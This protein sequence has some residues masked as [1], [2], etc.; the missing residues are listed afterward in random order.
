MIPGKL[1]IFSILVALSA[2]NAY[3]ADIPASVVNECTTNEKIYF[4]TKIRVNAD[5]TLEQKTGAV[6]DALTGLWIYENETEDAIYAGYH[7]RKHYL[8][9]AIVFTDDGLTTI[10]CDS[11]NM[12]QREGSIHRKAPQWKETLNSRIR[13]KVSTVSRNLKSGKIYLNNLTELHR[14]GFVTKEE[15]ETIKSRIPTE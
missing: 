1:L 12:K 11:R 14:K 5:L 13:S 4:P 9:F 6:M 3:A 2:A 8:K 7:V 10:I 15:Y